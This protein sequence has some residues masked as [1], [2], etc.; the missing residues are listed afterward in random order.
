MRIERND[1]TR[2]LEL[3]ALALVL[4]NIVAWAAILNR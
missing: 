1:A 2:T 4:A 3:V